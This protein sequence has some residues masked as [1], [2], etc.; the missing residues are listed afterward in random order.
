M[1]LDKKTKNE[2]GAPAPTSSLIYCGPNITR[3]MLLQFTVYK[4]GMPKHLDKHIEK[5]PGIKHLFVPVDG[6]TKTMEAVRKSG[7][8]ENTWFKQIAEYIKGGAN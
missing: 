7:T 6:F 1:S 4:E 8:A 5:C 3:A 2:P